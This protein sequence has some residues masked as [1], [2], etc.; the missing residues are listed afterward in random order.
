M[1]PEKEIMPMMAPAVQKQME[2]LQNREYRTRRIPGGEEIT[3]GRSA[4]LFLLCIWMLQISMLGFDRK[5]ELRHRRRTQ[6]SRRK[7]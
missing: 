4:G 2:Y 5:Y 1:T 6:W 3:D 7:N